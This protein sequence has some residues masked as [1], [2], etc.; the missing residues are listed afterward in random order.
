MLKALVETE[1]TDQIDL[2]NR[3]TIEVHTASFR[4]TRGYSV[5]AAILDEVAF[6]ASED[7]AEPKVSLW[8]CSRVQQRL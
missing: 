4:T 8:T 1:R 3:V 7:A 6:W 5:A 2:T